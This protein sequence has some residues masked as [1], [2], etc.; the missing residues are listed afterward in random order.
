M[1]RKT[2]KTSERGEKNMTRG[3]KLEKKIKRSRR[4]R[5]KSREAKRRKRGKVEDE[6]RD[7]R[8]GWDGE[9]ERGLR[10]NIR[11][12]KRGGEIRND[13]I[14]TSTARMRNL[15]LEILRERDPFE[16]AFPVL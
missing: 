15:A 9:K 1:K 6:K 13:L 12:K 4:R 14:Q 2:N 7:M 16:E 11:K 8:K 10:Q 3:E 5:K